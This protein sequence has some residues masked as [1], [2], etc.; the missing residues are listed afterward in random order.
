MT[1]T[2]LGMIDN[3][4]RMTDDGCW[5]MESAMEE[6]EQPCSKKQNTGINAKMQEVGEENHALF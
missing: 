4:Q 2:R 5:M 3:G 6:S 1:D